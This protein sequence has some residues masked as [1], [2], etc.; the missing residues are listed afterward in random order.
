MY[1]MDLCQMI[2]CESPV[3]LKFSWAQPASWLNHQLP[4]L[5]QQQNLSN[6]WDTG[7]VFPIGMVQP[8]FRR[9]PT[10]YCFTTVGWI[11]TASILPAP[12][13]TKLS[14]AS[15][16]VTTSVVGYPPRFRTWDFKGNDW[17]GCCVFILGIDFGCWLFWLLVAVGLFVVCCCR[18][19]YLMCVPC[20][21]QKRG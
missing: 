10:G 12:W 8:R 15:F 3:L 21:S 5:N 4:Q 17:C 14:A 16:T 13:I 9:E 11:G 19:R 2:D 20:L 18:Q 6:M 7:H 1:C